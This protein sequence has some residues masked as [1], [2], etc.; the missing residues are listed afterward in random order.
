MSN[1]VKTRKV[2]SQYVTEPPVKLLAR[3]PVTPNTITWLGFL[4][5]AGAAALIATEHL[6]AA[7]FIV[8]VAGVFD[9]LDGALARHKLRVFRSEIRR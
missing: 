5:T 6:F 2:I 8:L 3:T 1:L 4:I 7:G 9:M